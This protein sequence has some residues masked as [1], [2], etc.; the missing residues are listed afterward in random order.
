[1]KAGVTWL[2]RLHG[3]SRARRVAAAYRQQ[4]GADDALG[5]LILSDLAHYCRAGQSSF[6]AGDPHQTAFNEGARDVFLH[7]A[8]MC[9]VTPA[10]FAGLVE[11]VIDER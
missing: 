8:E 2:L 1:M 10:D 9:G 11:E 3:R 6:V 7:V 4:L 5:R